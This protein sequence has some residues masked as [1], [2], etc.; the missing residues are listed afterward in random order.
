MPSICCSYT[1]NMQNWYIDCSK[2][3]NMKS[4]HT[5]TVFSLHSAHVDVQYL[6]ILVKHEIQRVKK[7]CTYVGSATAKRNFCSKLVLLMHTLCIYWAYVVFNHSQGSDHVCLHKCNA[8]FDLYIS[9]KWNQFPFL[10]LVSRGRHDHHSPYSTKLPKNIAD[11]VLQIV[12]EHECLDL[13]PRMY[14]IC[15]PYVITDILNYR[16]SYAFSS[17]CCIK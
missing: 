12:R 5:A 8:R 9:I 6:Q 16:S 17:V 15:S 2:S 4:W 10:L 11:E 13:T 1:K 14:C 3:I 7:E